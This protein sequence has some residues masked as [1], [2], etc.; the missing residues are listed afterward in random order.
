M[1]KIKFEIDGQEIR[2]ND[3]KDAFQALMLKVVDEHIRRKV[4]AIR[5][6]ETGEW[7]VI[8]ARGSS[9]ENLKFEISGSPELVK[10][11]AE[12]LGGQAIDEE[13]AMESKM[14]DI[15]EPTKPKHQATAFLCHASENKPLARRIAEAFMAEGIETFLALI[16]LLVG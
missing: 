10:I 7:P 11:I 1:L 5:H 15:I 16:A 9:L 13:N 14:T 6:P 3:I 8:V 4:G 2:S 12:R